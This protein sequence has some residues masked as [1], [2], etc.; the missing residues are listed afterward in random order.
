M[1]IIS[2]DRLTNAEFEESLTARQGFDLDLDPDLP[3]I[4]A[5][6]WRAYTSNEFLYNSRHLRY[7]AYHDSNVIGIGHLSFRSDPANLDLATA[8][9]DGTGEASEALLRVM[10]DA[11]EADNRTSLLATGLQTQDRDQF[12]TSHAL[13]HRLTERLSD[14][15]VTAVDAEMMDSWI[16]RR[17]ERAADI[18]LI[19]WTGPTPEE[20]VPQVVDAM[21]GMN[22]APREDMDEADEAMTPERLRLYEAGSSTMGE[23]HLVLLAVDPDGR[24]AGLT[25]VEIN[26]HRPA[27]SW[28]SDTV[29]LS[30]YRN[31]G[32]G[33]WL[34]AENWR[35]LREGRPEVTR[36]RTG[37][38]E[39]N[40]PMLGINVAM[41]Y[42]PTHTY[43]YW[44]GERTDVQATLAAT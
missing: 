7:S 37:N 2:L 17:H 5:D 35:R 15:D 43:G 39:S 22:D 18:E 20:W 16:D 8:R 19:G 28:Q 21:D 12:L 41:G 11:A 14:L 25:A 3:P 4:T 23:E 1:R 31:R 34:K 6:E 24:A 26:T 42:R 30:G 38:A 44:Q 13:T 40:G 10:C 33:R 29:V 32:I 27:T 36:L 9:I